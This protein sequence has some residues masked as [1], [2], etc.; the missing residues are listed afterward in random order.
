MQEQEK[1]K[2][3]RPK[4]DD[5]KT[6]HIRIRVTPQEKKMLKK[7][8]MSY[9][10]NKG[11]HILMPTLGKKWDGEKWIPWERE[12]AAANR[13]AHKALR[14]SI[15]LIMDDWHKAHSSYN[16]TE[17]EVNLLQLLKKQQTE[18]EQHP[19]FQKA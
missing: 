14:F 11:L 1:K 13:I 7:Q 2:V 10:I 12:G 6:E 17:D 15:D 3:G 4:A 18:L 9:L 16:L 8:N 5:P 19:T